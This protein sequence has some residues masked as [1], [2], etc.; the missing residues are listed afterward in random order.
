MSQAKNQFTFESGHTGHT[1]SPAESHGIVNI[2]NTSNGPVHVN[3]YNDALPSHRATSRPSQ[4]RNIP[5]TL[6]D[7]SLHSGPDTVNTSSTNPSVPG[8]SK[9][10][11]P[12]NL[13]EMVTKFHAMKADEKDW[14]TIP[15][16]PLFKKFRALD[17][18]E[19]AWAKIPNKFQV[20]MDDKICRLNW[21]RFVGDGQAPI[22][23]FTD[24]QRNNLAM[25][26]HYIRDGLWPYMLS[27]WKDVSMACRAHD[28]WVTLQK[29]REALPESAIP[30]PRVPAG[31]P[32]VD[33][34]AGWEDLGDEW[35]DLGDE[36]MMVEFIGKGIPN[37][38]YKSHCKGSGGDTAM[39]R[40]KSDVLGWDYRNSAVH[41]NSTHAL[42]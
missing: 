26:D 5:G 40:S 36:E 20:A 18:A 3:I 31:R 22:R 4:P 14:T 16:K 19:K 7:I 32:L 35:M 27:T 2:S 6:V 37:Y 28:A 23:D 39:G 17:E 25:V 21:L 38:D 33:I 15:D 24:E 9:T 11:K 8:T 42:S 41:T 10:T 1:I 30:P 13:S 12:T 34:S 29:A